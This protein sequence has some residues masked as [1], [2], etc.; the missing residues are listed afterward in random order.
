MSKLSWRLN[1]RFENKQMMNKHKIAQALQYNTKRHI[2]A[3]VSRKFVT[4]RP[5]KE[6]FDRFLERESNSNITV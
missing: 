3:Q 2:I 1:Y 6:N 5:K 4:K